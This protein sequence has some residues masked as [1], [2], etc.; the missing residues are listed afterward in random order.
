MTAPQLD[1]TWPPC[2]F[3]GGPAQGQYS[4]HRDGFGVG[5]EVDLCDG[6][7]SEPEPTCEVIW[8]RIAQPSDDPDA[9]RP[10]HNDPAGEAS[11]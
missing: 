10:G 6:C 4:I 2:A 5:P 9:H 8:D 1:I 11:R 7:G 3:C